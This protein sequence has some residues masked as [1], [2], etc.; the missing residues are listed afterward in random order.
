MGESAAHGGIGSLYAFVLDV[1]DLDA[2]RKFWSHVLDVDVLYQ[3]HRYV[4]LG[5]QGTRPTLLLQK[6]SD[7]HGDKNRAHIDLDVADLDAAISRVL[8]LGGR[9]LRAVNEYG[10]AWVVMSDPDGN[11][12]CL[13]KHA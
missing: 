2:G 7:P 4:R 11:E 3:D 12:F 1:N 6:V 9:Q 5:H 8:V 13:I 10:L